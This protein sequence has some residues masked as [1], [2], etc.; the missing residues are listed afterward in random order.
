VEKVKALTYEKIKE[1][2]GPYLTDNE[3]EAVL[4]RKELLLKEIEAMIKE[5]G[6]DKF[7]Y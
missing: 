6:E 3:I 1:A 2:V 7:L 4:I 5:I